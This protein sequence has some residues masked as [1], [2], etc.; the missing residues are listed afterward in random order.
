MDLKA[1][2]KARAEAAERK[3]GRVLAL[4]DTYA[5]AGW[6]KTAADILEALNGK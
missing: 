1:T 5:S 4:V 3:A 6:P 2:Y